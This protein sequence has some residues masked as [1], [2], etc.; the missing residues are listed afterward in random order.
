VRELAGGKPSDAFSYRTLARRKDIRGYTRF[1]KVDAPCPDRQTHPAAQYGD[2]RAMQEHG[3]GERRRGG[4]APIVRRGGTVGTQTKGR[5]A[6]TQ[7]SKEFAGIG[8]I[9]WVANLMNWMRRSRA[10]LL[11]SYLRKFAV[12]I[13]RALTNGTVQQNRNKSMARLVTC[14]SPHPCCPCV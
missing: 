6:K 10:T 5:E 11:F 13:T 14:T 4:A 3:A 1:A 9:K 2:A 8:W 7:T 12:T